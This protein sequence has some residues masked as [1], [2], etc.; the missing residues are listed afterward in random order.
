MTD[1]DF[2]FLGDR[3]KPRPSEPHPADQ[4]ST[5][6][7]VAIPL[8]Q[9][10]PE[11]RSKFQP[12]EVVHHFAYIDAKGGCAEGSTAKQWIAIT[13]RRVLFEASVK[14]GD[15]SPTTFKHQTGSIPMSKVSYVGTATSAESEG[16]G[17]AMAHHSQL[18]INSSGGQIILAIPTKEEAE[19]AKEV[20]DAIISQT[21]RP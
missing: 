4:R 17:C 2:S 1:P 10:P 15:Q 6:N 19:R 12:G 18:R 13:D 20:I 3:S 14:D 8:Q 7:L 5:H 21:K 11:L 16:C 9:L